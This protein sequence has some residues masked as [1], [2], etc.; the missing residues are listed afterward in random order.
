MVQDIRTE[1]GLRKRSAVKVTQQFVVVRVPQS[2]KVIV[3]MTRATTPVT[4][5]VSECTM[6]PASRNWRLSLD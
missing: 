6:K 3:T 5:S 2:M 1:T 4:R